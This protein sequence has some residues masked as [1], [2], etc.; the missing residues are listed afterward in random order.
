MPKRKGMLNWAAFADWL[1]IAIGILA[2]VVNFISS[3]CAG[4]IL[5]YIAAALCLSYIVYAFIL[6]CKRALFDW[7]LIYGHFLLKV[8][9][10]VVLV[11]SLLSSI[12]Y[13]GIVDSSK[14]LVYS[15]ELY[16]C[17]DD[18]LPCAVR[19]KQV[20]PNIFW[21][22][23]YHFI[24]P[25]N[26]HMTTSE[27]GRIWAAV[28]AMFG[29]FLLNG[30]LVSS[31]V[32]WLD[33]RKERWQTGTIRYKVR[34][35]GKYQ[36]A[37]VIG[38]NEIASAVIKNLFTPK[39]EGEINYKSEGEN[40][41]VLLHTSRNPIDVRAELSSHIS[42]EQMK[43]V[44]IYNGLRD[45][46]NEIEGLHLEYATE[47]YVLGESTMP[48]GGETYHDALNMHCVN[49]IAD[50]LDRSRERRSKERLKNKDRSVRKVCKI[51][52]EYQTTSSIFQFSDI[53]DKIKD[54]LIF[55]PFNRYE[56][57]ARK[58]IVDGFYNDIEYTPLEGNGISADSDE[59]VHLVIVGMSKM[60]IA[61]GIETLLQAHYLNS[62]I[63]RSRVTFIDTN[64]DKEMSFFKGRYSNMFELIRTRYIDA[65]G[66]EKAVSYDLPWNDPMSEDDCKWKHLGSDGE[67]FLDVEIEFIKG[68]IE[69]EG[70]RK[71]LREISADVSAK[72]TM[73][74]CLTHTHQAIAASLYMP[75]E[76][77]KSSR[78]QQIWVYQR[79]SEDILMNLI[80]GKN[81]LRY[82]KIRPFGMLYGEY[83]T[84]RSL[85]LKALLVN[86]AYDIANGY[87]KA[88]W[89]LDISDKNDPGYIEARKS[90]NKLSVDKMW[91]N[92]YYADSIYV[93][94]RNI[95][96]DKPMYK[97]LDTISKWNLYTLGKSKLL[98]S[99]K[100]AIDT[101]S[102]QLSLCEHNRWNIQQLILGYAPCDKELD[103]IFE[104][105]NANEDKVVVLQ[106][107]LKWKLT[108]LNIPTCNKSKI[109]DDVKECPL[110]IHPNICSY[111]HLSKTDSGAQ[112][113]DEDLNNSIPDI[114]SIV[115]GYKS[116]RNDR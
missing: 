115:D 1:A 84:D 112:K 79:E 64:A 91:S 90:W 110:R 67:N 6:W 96:Q 39:K 58:V 76:V 100:T 23:Y 20:N 87:N 85:Y 51:M 27:G 42:P 38:A 45:S 93:K 37:V 74:F 15:K 65:S 14:E 116:K 77:Y 44:I 94:I 50:T 41:Y 111:E 12:G 19:Q 48:D 54:N 104:S 55:I 97:S 62:R 32:G 99:I 25:G 114:I 30:L 11:P 17:S 21:G 26:Q 82:D 73:A 31:I 57:W 89:P 52:F 81:D 98:E 109:K 5:C 80:N 29:V 88:G 40:K 28:I 43:R 103:S 9:C 107:Y 3:T 72:L 46:A 33:K 95:L 13:L 108:N 36:Y 16:E 35:L 61:M 60:G 101:Y 75:V 113:Y 105:I 49:L 24:D 59:F 7:H 78:L 8:C 69:S 63:A 83:M 34:H 53:S 68:E 106:R 71:C 92:K 2:I 86:V 10:L 18:Q 56:S 66:P 102:E 22:T 47:I 70:V 4:I